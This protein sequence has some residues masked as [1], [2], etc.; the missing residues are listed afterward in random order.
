MAKSDKATTGSV[1]AWDILPP[2]QF[3]NPR[4]RTVER[5]EE[6][7]PSNEPQPARPIISPSASTGTT[8][9]ATVTAAVTGHVTEKCPACGSPVQADAEFCGECGLRL[10]DESAA[11]VEH[12]DQGESRSVTCPHCG[13]ELELADSDDGVGTYNCPEC[14]NDFQ[15]P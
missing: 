8:L 12:A 5:K 15:V 6:G 10:S 13:E 4:M 14:G 9:D 3:I 1:P 7:K 11:D 2:F